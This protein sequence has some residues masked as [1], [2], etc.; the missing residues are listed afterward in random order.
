VTTLPDLEPVAVAEAY[1]G[2][3]L[4]E[5]SFCHEKQ[6]LGIVKRRQHSWAAQ[7]L[8]LLLARLAPHLV[9]WSKQW[10]SRLPQLHHR[11]RGYGVVRLLQEVWTVPG[12]LPWQHGE[13]VRMYCDPSHPLARLLQRGFAALFRECV[14]VSCLR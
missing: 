3:A 12:V 10:P 8:V 14:L 7:P 6:G 9:V 5:A 11:L 2:R 13:L 1:D 4:M